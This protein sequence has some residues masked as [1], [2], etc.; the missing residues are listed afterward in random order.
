MPVIVQNT[1]I[2]N[3]IFSGKSFQILIPYLNAFK[4]PIPHAKDKTPGKPVTD[5]ESFFRKRA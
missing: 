4:D 5:I 2:C 1:E 3:S